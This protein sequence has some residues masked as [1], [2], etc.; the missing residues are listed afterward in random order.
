MTAAAG[1]PEGRLL[2]VELGRA[3]AALSVVAFH[4]NAASDEFAGPDWRWLGVGAHGVDFF[5]VLSGF[6]IV[7]AHGHEVGR[8][9]AA[10]RYLAKRAIRLLPLLWGA[11]LA[12]TAVRLAAGAPLTRSLQAPADPCARVCTQVS[13]ATWGIRLSERGQSH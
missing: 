8:P 13:T 10:G 4:A 11:I 6:I 2:L 5:F 12:W 9:G 1:R 7:A 3:A